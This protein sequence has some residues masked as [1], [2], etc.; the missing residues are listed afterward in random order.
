MAVSRHHFD[1][2]RNRELMGLDTRSELAARSLAEL[3][4]SG[5]ELR[6]RW[7]CALQQG[8]IDSER[9]LER[10]IDWAAETG[11]GEICFKELYVSS[12]VESVYYAREANRWSREHQ[13]SLRLVTDFMA[14]RGFEVAERL[15]WGAPIFEGAWNGR[16]LRIA[17][18]TEPSISWELRN[19]LC[20]SWNLMADGRCLASLEDS[21]SEVVPK[22]RPDLK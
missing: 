1:G 6:L 19:G 16:R 15:P 7:I 8:G 17:A 13:V 22:D 9:A 11:A 18:Y 3:G 5:L 12:S 10:Y 4:R 14:N 2:E 20:R 21:G